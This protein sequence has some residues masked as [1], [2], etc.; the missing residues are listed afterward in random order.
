VSLVE[1]IKT[2]Q[3][4]C[5][6]EVDG[7]FGPRTAAAVLAELH[8]D[9]SDGHR[10]PLQELDAR[11]RATI[12]TLDVK[13]QAAFTTFALLAK[14]T[15][16]TFGCDY[17]AISGH[18]TWEEQDELFR[19]VPQVTRAKGGYSNHNF[20]I[21][22]DF[23]VFRGKVYLDESK[24]ELARKV[25]TACAAHAKDCGLEWG[26]DWK[27]MKDFP[28]YEMRTALT[29]AEKRKVYQEKGTVL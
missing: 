2:I 6:A 24:P 7:I 19:R 26:G 12:A 17:V 23:A 16:A 29:M 4:H 13:A 9:S 3:R 5:G 21:A 25:H 11:T 20:G 8:K 10:P 18:R 27:R 22:A 15:A 14:A 1:Q 28:H